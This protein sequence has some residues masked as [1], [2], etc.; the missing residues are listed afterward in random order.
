MPG[1]TS[2]LHA[3]AFGHTSR[4]PST[5]TAPS[6]KRHQ[7]AAP[8]S[9]PASVHI[10]PLSAADTRSDRQS[11]QAQQSLPAFVKA[12]AFS[13]AKPGYAFK[14]GSK[15]VGYYLE[16]GASDVPVSKPKQQKQSET[17][18]GRSG[19]S[20][21]QKQQRQQQQAGDEGEASAMSDEDMQPVKGVHLY[22]SVPLQTP[23]NLS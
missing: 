8:A 19:V 9:Q 20:K 6:R 17:L 3:R 5:T 7:T 22:Q 10:G 13:I 11:Q 14:K 12:K 18:P 16:A 23:L 21:R 2:G 1:S 15:G 4:G